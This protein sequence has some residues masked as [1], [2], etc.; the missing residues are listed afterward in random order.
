MS[1]TEADEYT[2]EELA[3]Q[4]DA[5]KRLLALTR[6]N[7]DAVGPAIRDAVSRACDE[8]ERAVRAEAELAA[9]R[10]TVAD[11]QVR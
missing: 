11:W 1:D 4:L 3:A 10:A 8:R 7:L 9:L 5:T 2:R 6:A